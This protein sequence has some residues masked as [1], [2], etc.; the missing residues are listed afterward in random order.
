[1]KK[2][3]L[4]QEKIV[5]D[6][7]LEFV[8]ANGYLVIL[9]ITV[10]EPNELSISGKCCG[11]VG[12]VLND[13]VPANKWQEKLLLL[14]DEHLSKRNINLDLNELKKIIINIDIEETKRKNRS[15][16]NLSQREQYNFLIDK[17]FDEDTALILM[18]FI[19]K[20]DLTD[21]DLKN[22][23]ID[24]DYYTVQG[25]TYLAGREETIKKY[26]YMEIRNY[27][28]ELLPKVPKPLVNYLDVDEFKEDMLLA[29]YG[30]LLNR[31][32]GSEYTFENMMDGEIYYA[33]EQ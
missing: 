22:I 14:W 8:D 12:A 33:L 16:K 25:V 28:D 6:K 20:H 10:N 19:E 5:F 24:D 11:R 4:T 15:L 29:G 31:Y 13:I 18:M 23:Y 21:E 3:K 2:E 32:D 26:A 17:G 9:D 27:L 1:M 7:E 30:E